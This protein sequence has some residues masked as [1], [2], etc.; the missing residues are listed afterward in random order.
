MIKEI[1]KDDYDDNVFYYKSPNLDSGS[2]GRGLGLGKATGG[3]VGIIE[4]NQFSFHF[5]TPNPLKPLL[6]RLPESPLFLI[7]DNK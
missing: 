7:P 1:N 5:P 4:I 2:F 6:R 3:G